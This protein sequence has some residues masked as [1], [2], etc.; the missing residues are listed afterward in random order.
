AASFEPVYFDLVDGY[1]Q[2]KD[3]DKAIRLLRDGAQ[4]WPKDPEIFNALGVVQT[5]RG[6]LPE[7]I[8]SFEDALA[9]A[10]EDALSHF[11]L[12]R[13]YELRYFRSRRYVTQTKRWI[14]N[15]KDRTA[16]TE[17]YNRYLA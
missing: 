4:I 16:A 13:A 10:P 3:Y 12:G 9:A 14:A 8:R 6:A 7:A 15:E 17:H 2:L 11:N 1:L 5:V